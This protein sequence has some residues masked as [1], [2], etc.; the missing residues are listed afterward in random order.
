MLGLATFNGPHLVILDE[1]T[2]HLDIDSR[3]AL[4]S[5]IND[6]PGAVILVSHDRYLIEACA[7]RLWLVAG[8]AVTPFDG[9]LDDYQRLVLSDRGGD[10][11]ANRGPKDTAPRVNR[12]ELR[13]AAA[14]K[15]V[16]LAPL[17]RRIVDAEKAVKRLSEDIARTDAALAAPG[18][19]ARDPA[20]AAALAKA[21][22][23]AAA[24]LSRAEDDWLAASAE[25]EA[26]MA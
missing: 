22:S 7:D 13:R 16:E 14:E 20:K 5:A 21:R 24:A 9:D 12:T 18:L 2:N 8:G 25:F 17:R 1:P 10:K 3:S 6:Y 11:S 26:A 15:R 19:F 4:I 23:D